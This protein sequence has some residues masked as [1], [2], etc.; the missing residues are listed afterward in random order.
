MAGAHYIVRLARSVLL[1]SSYGYRSV[2]CCSS[3]PNLRSFELYYC[4]NI[5]IQT[6]IYT[7]NVEST[8]VEITDEEVY[9]LSQYGYSLSTLY[10]E[11]LQSGRDVVVVSVDPDSGQKEEVERLESVE[12]FYDWKDRRKRAR[13]KIESKIEDLIRQNKGSV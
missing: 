12:D 3:M 6:V 2:S 13:E 1:R 11:I 9:D 10:L 4:T 5:L 7:M 8:K